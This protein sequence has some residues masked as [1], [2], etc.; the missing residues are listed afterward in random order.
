MLAFPIL[1]NLP[2]GYTCFGVSQNTE[3]ISL[4]WWWER[5]QN[6]CEK[7]E[8]KLCK[9]AECQVLFKLFH[10]FCFSQL[11]E[12]PVTAFDGTKS[13]IIS[14]T[15]WLGGKNPFLGI[16]YIV[17]GSLCILLGVI[18]LFIHLKFGKKWVPLWFPLV[19]PSPL[20]FSS[21]SIWLCI[22]FKC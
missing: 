8:E 5:G 6:S 16:A 12:Y 13:I 11:S 17:V 3:I 1:N 21:P 18:F 10:K 22:I 19:V 9:Q 4:V 14:T 7:L 2:I 15:S 20:L